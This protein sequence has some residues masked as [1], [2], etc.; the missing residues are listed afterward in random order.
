MSKK[1]DHRVRSKIIQ[2]GVRKASREKFRVAHNLFFEGS[3]MS[4][5]AKISSQMEESFSQKR[6]YR[7]DVESAKL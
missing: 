1:G 2:I 3:E 5:K 4:K 7:S 6:E